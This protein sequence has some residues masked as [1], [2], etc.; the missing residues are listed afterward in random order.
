M[1]T[2]TKVSMIKL[3]VSESAKAIVR[4]EREKKRWL[5]DAVYN[6]TPLVEASKVLDPSGD[7]QTGGP[8]AVSSS[9]WKR[10]LKGDLIKADSF[11]AFCK[12]LGLPWQL[13]ANHNS[14]CP[15]YG[16][17]REGEKL[18]DV[19]ENYLYQHY[20]QACVIL[21]ESIPNL[22]RNAESSPCKNIWNDLDTAIYL[23]HGLLNK[24]PFRVDLNLAIGDSH[25]QLGNW[26]EA[27][28]NYQRALEYLPE[29]RQYLNCILYIGINKF[30]LGDYNQA[31]K[32]FRKLFSVNDLY[33]RNKAHFFQG[34]IEMYQGQHQNALNIF[35]QNIEEANI[36]SDSLFSAGVYHFL[37]RT[38]YEMGY[39][40][41]ALNM[42]SEQC[43]ILEKENGSPGKFAHASRW[44]AECHWKSGNTDLA[45]SHLST[46][47]DLFH[48]LSP[49]SS[50]S[51]IAHIGLHRAK[52]S[53][54]E[55]KLEFAQE[56]LFQSI[57][58]WKEVGYKKGIADCQLYLGKIYEMQSSY[59]D[60]IAAYREADKIYREQNNRMLFITRKKLERLNIS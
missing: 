21:L 25:C 58:D 31:S 38:Y 3:Q 54:V 12:V 49:S 16:S 14:I 13:V 55:E 35:K 22:I 39:R 56:N 57:K 32:L 26:I 23:A 29:G 17:T 30:N 8:Y 20:D 34:W 41:K 19:F 27:N 59:N 53:I 43:K 48:S 36:L 40:E 4:C 6:D 5:S 7:W 18:K 51:G 50:K 2:K 44:I 11:K 24:L 47:Y 42:F 10:F 52:I 15:S 45:E 9:T 33:I 1:Q 46:A 37:G 28:K 60:S